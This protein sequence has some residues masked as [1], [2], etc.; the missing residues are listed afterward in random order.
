VAPSPTPTVAPAQAGAYRACRS[1]QTHVM[2][3][4]LYEFLPSTATL[5]ARSSGSLGS[6]P[7][8]IIVS[9]FTGTP[10][11]SEFPC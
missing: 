3:T 4:S 2:G 7:C 10:P 1:S 9:L 11:T 8:T 6:A 5:T